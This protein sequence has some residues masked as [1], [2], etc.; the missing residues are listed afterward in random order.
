MISISQ[1]DEAKKEKRKT[2]HTERGQREAHIDDS[3]RGIRD[4]MRNGTLVLLSTLN[5]FIYVDA[6]RIQY[7]MYTVTM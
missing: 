6:Q 1:S 3:A 7:K 4:K 2:K 5:R